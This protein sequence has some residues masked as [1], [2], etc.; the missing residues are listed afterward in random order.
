MI[1]FDYENLLK[2]FTPSTTS[3]FETTDHYLL[4]NL[5]CLSHI[6][7]PLKQQHWRIFKWFVKSR[8][9]HLSTVVALLYRSSVGNTFTITGHINCAL[10]LMGHKINQFN[11]KILPL[12][13]RVISLDW[14]SSIG[15]S[16][17]FRFDAMLYST[18]VN[19]NSDA[20]HMK[21]SCGPYLAC[22]LQV[23][24]SWYRLS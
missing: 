3:Q 5:K 15:L 20:G 16:W 7:L 17:S 24:C 11:P 18:L 22:R 21:C 1:K 6:I 13:M 2:T 8:K 23:P 14:L 19:K 4:L 9:N 12:T 10:S